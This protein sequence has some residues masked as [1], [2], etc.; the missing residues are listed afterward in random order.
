M[1][2]QMMAQD[3]LVMQ[4]PAFMW[5]VRAELLRTHGKEPEKYI[6]PKP[7][8]EGAKDAEDIFWNA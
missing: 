1:M 6:G 7:P 2:Y 5:E 4:H 3:P 8:I